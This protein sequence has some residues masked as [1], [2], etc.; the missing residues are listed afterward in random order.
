MGTIVVLVNG[1]SMIKALY[2]NKES[3]S[4][5]RAVQYVF[6]YMPIY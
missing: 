2:D 6:I 4:A 5:P 3:F 1:T